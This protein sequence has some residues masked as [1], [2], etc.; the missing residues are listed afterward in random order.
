MK[1]TADPDP[2]P[3]SAAFTAAERARS[4]A[5]RANLR[6][7]DVWRKQAG[8]VAIGALKFIC[9]VLLIAL[10]ARAAGF[11]GLQAGSVGVVIGMAVLPLWPSL[12]G[13]NVFRELA[14]Q[15]FDAELAS[16]I[17]GITK[18]VQALTDQ[19]RTFARE[20]K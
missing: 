20:R 16:Q 15:A 19:A 4:A 14:D 8:I 2:R 5:M 1:R 7:R 13:K 3:Q 9:A 11:D 17:E 12:F 18:S 6:S 10:A